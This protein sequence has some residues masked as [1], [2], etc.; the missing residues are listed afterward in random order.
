MDMLRFRADASHRGARWPERIAEGQY[1]EFFRSKEN[2]DATMLATPRNRRSVH[3][4]GRP[5]GAARQRPG[6]LCYAATAPVF[7]QRV[8]ISFGTRAIASPGRQRL[9]SGGPTAR[10]VHRRAVRR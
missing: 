3:A 5:G 10:L 2:P 9:A 6:F 8:A 7:R 1:T 4:R